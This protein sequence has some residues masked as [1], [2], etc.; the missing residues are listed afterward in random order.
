M[1]MRERTTSKYCTIGVQRR[2]IKINDI[3][4]LILSDSLHHNTRHLLFMKFDSRS[5]VFFR[6]ESNFVD[7]IEQ[8]NR[9]I[10][11]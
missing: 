3:S 6:Y 5:S 11:R 4:F 2:V 1:S 10:G 9:S 8:N 7:A